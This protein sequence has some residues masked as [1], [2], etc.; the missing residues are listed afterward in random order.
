VPFHLV[1]TTEP[2]QPYNV[3]IFQRQAREAIAGV[4]AR[5]HLPI[6]CGAVGCTCG[7]S[8]KASTFLAGS[9]A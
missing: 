8:P 7:P 5:R 9:A 3:A 6:L 1:D 2:D 4:H